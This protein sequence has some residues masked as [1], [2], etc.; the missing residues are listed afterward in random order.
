MDII[1]HEEIKRV[2]QSLEHSSLDPNIVLLKTIMRSVAQNIL[3][4]D[5]QHQLFELSKAILSHYLSQEIG[6]YAEHK[7]LGLVL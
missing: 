3:Q 1:K 4:D 6:E 5:F 7:E 2:F